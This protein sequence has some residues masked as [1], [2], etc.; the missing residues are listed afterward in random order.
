MFSFCKRTGVRTRDDSPCSGHEQSLDE[1]LH[2][3]G[4]CRS[5]Q[6]HTNASSHT[7]SGNAGSRLAPV[8][9]N[10]PRHTG[11]TYS[12][13]DCAGCRPLRMQDRQHACVTSKKNLCSIQRITHYGCDVKYTIFTWLID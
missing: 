2:S 12:S 4:T 9:Q 8:V 7:A 13:E 1:D 3:P 5:H 11:S 10:W 6:E